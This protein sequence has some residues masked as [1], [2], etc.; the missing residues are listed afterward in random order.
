MQCNVSQKKV[1]VLLQDFTLFWLVKAFKFNFHRERGYCS[2]VALRWKGEIGSKLLCLLSVVDLEPIHLSRRALLQAKSPFVANT[3]E[4]E[5]SNN[6]S[7]EATECI[8]P[9]RSY[10][11]QKVVATNAYYFCAD[12]ILDALLQKWCSEWTGHERVREIF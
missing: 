10:L 1:M 7:E 9:P 11:P 8:R 2:R 6:S 4:E 5:L 12:Y 3:K